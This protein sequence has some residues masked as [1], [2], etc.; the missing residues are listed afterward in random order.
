MLPPISFDILL[1]LDLYLLNLINEYGTLVYAMLFLVILVETGLVIMP[2]LPGDSLLFVAGAFA[3]MGSLDVALLAVSLIAAAIIG[4]S[5]NYWLGHS[6]GRRAFSGKI[7][8]L[9]KENL[10][11]VEAF[12]EKHG[13]KTIFIARFIPFIRTFAPFVAGMGSMEYKRFIGYNIAGGAAWVS[14]FL[15]AGY[16]FGNIPLI[17]E[18]LTL[19]LLAVIIASILAAVVGFMREK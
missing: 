2:F 1:H 13:G 15:G 10:A 3:A 7:K 5:V 14:A 19:F 9:N 8:F 12:Y 4:D 6:V 11:R 18:T 16:L 17:K